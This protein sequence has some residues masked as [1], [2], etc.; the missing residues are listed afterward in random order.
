MPR[1][2]IIILEKHTDD[3]SCAMWADVPAARQ[4]RYADQNKVSAWSGAL[5]ADNTNL[6]NGVVA[7][8]VTTQRTPSGASVA[9]IQAFL[10]DQWTAYQAEINNYN[11]W[12]R[13]GS[14]WDGT[15]WTMVT[16]G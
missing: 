14:T 16:N 12:V 13:Y 2:N 11:P 7:E 4:S 8:R 9:Q 15:T 5:A 3:F 10:Q 1:L 6:K